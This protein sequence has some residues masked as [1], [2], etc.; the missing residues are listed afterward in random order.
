[1]GAKSFGDRTFKKWMNA[2]GHYG[3][4]ARFDM[5]LEDGVLTIGVDVR[6]KGASAGKMK[7]VW[8]TGIE[9]IWNKKVFFDDGGK[10]IPIA[11]DFDFVSS[12]QHHTVKVH[13]GTGRAHMLDWYKSNPWA[14]RYDDEIAAHEVGHMIGAFDEYKD[15]ATK[16]HFTTRHTLMADLEVGGF[17]RYFGTVEKFAEKASKSKLEVV[18]A[19]VGTGKADHFK[20]TSGKDGYYGGGGDDRIDGGGGAD[21][22]EGGSG[23]DRLDGGRGIDTLVGGKGRDTFVFDPSVA[24]GGGDRILDFSEEDDVIVFSQATMKLGTAGKLAAS[25]YVSGTAAIDADDRVIYDPA[26][27]ALYYDTNG[28]AEGGRIKVADIGKGLS[29]TAE[30][31]LIG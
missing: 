17:T 27:G 3:W 11:L 10:L 6:L 16:G 29:L 25:A 8:E 13:A 9:K 14:K 23:D 30:H 1:M 21:W 18:K 12:G 5:G 7:E 31:F 4:R 19:K 26:S 15:G 22:L 24:K 20:G 28:S 2:D